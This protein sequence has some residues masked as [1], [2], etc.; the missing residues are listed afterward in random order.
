[1]IKKEKKVFIQ[2][3]YN[4]KVVLVWDFIKIKKV[5][6]KITPFLKIRILNYKAWQVL[7]F[8][9]SKT[10]TSIIIDIL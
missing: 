7:R 6:R 2:I 3:L 1:M 4:W 10:L 5:K 9:I 8:Y